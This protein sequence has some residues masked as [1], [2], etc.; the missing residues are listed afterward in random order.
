MFATNLKTCKMQSL[1][2]AK[3]HKDTPLFYTYIH[4]KASTNEIFYV[5]KGHAKRAWSVSGRPA[6]WRNIVKKHG[7]VVE[8]VDSGISEE[9]AFEF[10]MFL[11]AEIGCKHNQKGPLINLTSGGDGAA[12]PSETSRKTIADKATAR[13]GEQQFK[14]RVVEAI[15]LSLSGVETRTALSEAAKRRWADPEYRAKQ[16][17]KVA[18]R[19]ELVKEKWQDPAYR[20]KIKQAKA[21]SIKSA[22]TTQRLSEASKKRWEDPSFR[23]KRAATVAANH[24][25]TS[26]SAKKKWDDP[27]YREKWFASRAA[28]KL[29][30]QENE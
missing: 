5:G 6:H 27:A 4:K 26:E 1:Q 13:W 9:Q 3:M 16:S 30:R 2:A 20:D 14:D 29:K 8:L 19:S 15:K 7:L 25:K 28:N 11:I 18:R 21:G 22:A 23:E 17:E 12:N 10:E 24:V